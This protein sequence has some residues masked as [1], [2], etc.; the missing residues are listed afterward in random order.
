MNQFL[1]ETL[2]LISLIAYK[3]VS[4]EY[5]FVKEATQNSLRCIIL[6]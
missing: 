4:F 5:A 6:V 3:F 1:I 2:S